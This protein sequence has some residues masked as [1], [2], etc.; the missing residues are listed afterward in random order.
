LH[1]LPTAR[2]HLS[3]QINSEPTPGEVQDASSA[4]LNLTDL[5]LSALN[6]LF[7]DNRAMRL[8]ST[9]FAFPRQRIPEGQSPDSFALLIGSGRSPGHA[10]RE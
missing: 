2:R 3:A 10:L 7:C 1:G 4:L 8:R 6:G 5:D 9:L